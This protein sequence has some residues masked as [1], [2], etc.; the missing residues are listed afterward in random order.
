MSYDRIAKKLAKGD[1]I[2]IDGGTGTDIQSRGVPMATET[3]GCEANLTHPALVRCVHEDY[4]AAGA[5]I[6]TANTYP[7]SPLLFNALG[8]DADMIRIDKE[9]LRSARQASDVRL[10]VAGSF[11]VRRP[12]QQGVDRVKAYRQW[13][14]KDARALL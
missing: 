6:V 2:I 11:S 8:R 5:E 4:I 7:T 1:I 9:A 3:C 13:S 10:P 14:E 12:M